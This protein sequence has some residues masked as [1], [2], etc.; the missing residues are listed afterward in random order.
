MSLNNEPS[1]FTVC[2]LA[3]KSGVR[4]NIIEVGLLVMFTSAYLIDA[5][6]WPAVLWLAFSAAALWTLLAS[7]RDAQMLAEEDVTDGLVMVT[8]FFIGAV[9][10]LAIACVVL[11][12]GILY[13]V[14]FVLAAIQN[15]RYTALAYEWMREI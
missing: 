2:W 1:N 5:I 14:I 10:L 6:L 9:L 4:Y 12:Y 13:G 15:L 7:T 11:P 8:D 3:L